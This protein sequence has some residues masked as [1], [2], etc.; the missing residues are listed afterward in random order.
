MTASTVECREGQH[1]ACVGDVWTRSTDYPPRCSCPCHTTSTP[2]DWSDVDDAIDRIQ[3]PLE[4]P[5]QTLLSASS[6]VSE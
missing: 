3:E 2:G 6:E 5:G 4:I 1:H